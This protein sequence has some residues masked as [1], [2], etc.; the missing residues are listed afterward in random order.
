MKTSKTMNT[1][2]EFQGRDETIKIIDTGGNLVEYLTTQ[3]AECP[4]FEAD[5]IKLVKKLGEGQAG[6]PAWLINVP[7]AGRRE[8]VA[9]IFT[10]KLEKIDIAITP[11]NTV[12]LDQVAKKIQ[13]NYGIPYNTTIYL[14]GGNSELAYKNKSKLYI[15]GN[16]KI[17]K[18]TKSEDIKRF[19]DP[20]HF[21]TIPAGSYVCVERFSEYVVGIIC[22][23]IF[24]KGMSAHF[25]DMFGFATCDQPVENEK[26]KSGK[27]I[28]GKF[29]K[30]VK[31]YVFMDK[32]DSTIKKLMENENGR[33]TN[34][35]I[36]GKINFNGKKYTE[37]DILCIQTLSAIS[38]MQQYGI[39]HG[40]LHLD[41]VFLEIVDKKTEYGNNF[42]LAADLW[43]Y[44]IFG[45]TIV[46]P[47]TT[48]IVKIGDFGLS[49]KYSLP[50]VGNEITLRSGYW[51]T[52]ATGNLDKNGPWLPNWF[53]TAYDVLYFL[54]NV[55]VAGGGTSF[56]QSLLKRALGLSEKANN[57]ELEAEIDVAFNKSNM[58]PR[59][60]ELNNYRSS[61]NP[62][63]IL[64]SDI[65]EDF[66]GV[67]AKNV[68][69]IELANI[70]SVKGMKYTIPKRVSPKKVSSKK[71]SSEETLEKFTDKIYD[72]SELIELETNVE[73]KPEIIAEMLNYIY[74]N[75]VYANKISPEIR[76]WVKTI[77][78]LN[79]KLI[80]PY[81]TQK[82][83]DYMGG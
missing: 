70:K 80:R 42:L 59:M 50:I 20:N 65:M 66:Q 44:T 28:E 73:K 43:E 15:M 4:L 45:D 75:N 79:K 53:T 24:R 23:N 19:D 49:V 46:I 60:T 27:N 1:S 8:Y 30:N 10:D 3:S 82:I 72:Y 21:N 67:P 32:I 34:S 68:T 9:K 40:D 7:G 37:L 62:R 74:K 41:N 51:Q 31:E 63:S 78:N 48:W 2:F 58:R 18:T 52:D 33:N 36:F 35:P 25:I 17:C 61:A 13:E 47:K 29:M 16:A 54:V 81:I 64:L 6:A 57:K 39:V 38:A 77:Y 71:V 22:G 26:D 76:T 11:G 55:Y 5:S 83:V 69:S 14:N 56:V 12:T